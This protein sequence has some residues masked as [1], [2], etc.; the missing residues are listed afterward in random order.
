PMALFG[1]G[2]GDRLAKELQVP[3]LGQIPLSPPVLEGADTGAPIVAS[4][5]QSH[6]AQKLTAVGT[7]IAQ[8]LGVRPPAR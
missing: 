8:Q 5:P 2:G 6:A 4:Q 7:S 3:L 1:S